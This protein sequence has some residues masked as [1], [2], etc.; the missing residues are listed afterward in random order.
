MYFL[1]GIIGVLIIIVLAKRYISIEE[2]TLI[3]KN[4][5][6]QPYSCEI[7]N[8]YVVLVL[9]KLHFMKMERFGL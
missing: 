6:I 8:D 7:H 9:P 4:A 5:I 2:G 1:V 3:L